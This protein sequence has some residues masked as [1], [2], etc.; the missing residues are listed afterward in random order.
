MYAFYL[1]QNNICKGVLFIFFYI[2]KMRHSTTSK[3]EIYNLIY[4][5]DYVYFVC[6]LFIEFI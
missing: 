1:F 4:L 2:Y 5:Y 3:Q 6:G